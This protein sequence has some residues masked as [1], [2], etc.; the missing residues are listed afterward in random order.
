MFSQTNVGQYVKES[1]GFTL[2]LVIKPLEGLFGSL[3]K[4]NLLLVLRTA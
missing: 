1:R 4:E 2:S 3:T